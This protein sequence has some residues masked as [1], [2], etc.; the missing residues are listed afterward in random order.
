M[1]MQYKEKSINEES[2]IESLLYKE[3]YEFDKKEDSLK[4]KQIVAETRLM[5]EKKQ[6]YFYW[7]GL[8][9]LSLLSFLGYRNFQNQNK[10]NR[11]AADAYAKERTELEL[12]SL[13]AQLNPH[14]IFNCIN[15][16]DA[17]IHSN[18]KYNATVYLNKFARLLRNILDSSK[19][20]TVSFTKDIDTLKL[21][22]ELEELRHENKFRTEFSID[23]GLLI[24]DYKVPAL[25]IQPFVENAIL[26]GLK[27]REDNSGLLQIEIKKITDKIEYTIKDNGIGREA[28]GLIAQN[29]ESSYGMQ[30]SY[31]RIKLFNKEEKPSVEITDLYNNSIAAGTEVKVLLNII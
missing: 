12:Q 10:I 27:N 25:I 24:N 23:D 8:G 6:K 28:A 9:L 19:L 21:Y 1:Y 5:T 7:T 11:L 18:D 20:T 15:S 2:I 26:H 16:I 3:H 22:V 29:K 17:F 4:Q 30:M 31:D 13:R 14:F